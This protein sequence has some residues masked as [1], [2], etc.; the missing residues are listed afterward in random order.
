MRADSALIS[1][2]CGD[3]LLCR[4]S[5]L[6]TPLSSKPRA[7][8][9]P[10]CSPATD[11]II[12]HDHLGTGKRVMRISAKFIVPIVVLQIAYGLAVFAL[13]RAY[14]KGTAETPIAAQ[15]MAGDTSLG[16]PSLN[17]PGLVIPALNTPGALGS[18]RPFSTSPAQGPASLAELTSQADD[19][20]W[21]SFRRAQAPQPRAGLPCRRPR[22]WTRAARSDRRQSAC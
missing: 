17:T 13:T 3:R 5:A 14:Y 8:S 1:E 12:R 19:A 4:T 10:V 6:A 9:R 20:F 7:R 18:L 21:A 11:G 22:T 15:P 16:L 2:R